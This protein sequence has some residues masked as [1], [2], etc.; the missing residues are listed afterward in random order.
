MAV[1]ITRNSSCSNHLMNLAA[2][3]PIKSTDYW[4]LAL[5]MK[6]LQ[7]QW[8]HH[9]CI[10]F[11]L[12]L[13]VKIVFNL[14]FIIISL[15]CDGKTCTLESLKA[16][17]FLPQFSKGQHNQLGTMSLVEFQSPLPH[18]FGSNSLVQNF[19]LYGQHNRMEPAS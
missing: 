1:A 16:V 15:Q 7:G 4:K 19:I 17:K 9:F 14:S 2:F 10:N 11:M 13:V 6:S 3:I 5:P 12:F 8:I 18:P